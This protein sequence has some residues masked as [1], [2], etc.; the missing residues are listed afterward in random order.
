MN[1]RFSEYQRRLRC[2]VDSSQSR[3]DVEPAVLASS[4]ESYRDMAPV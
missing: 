4:S 1:K 3:V 2:T